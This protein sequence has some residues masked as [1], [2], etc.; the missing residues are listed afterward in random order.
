[1]TLPVSFLRD[2][3]GQLFCEGFLLRYTTGC[4]YGFVLLRDLLASSA[5]LV[6]KIFFFCFFDDFTIGLEVSFYFCRRCKPGSACFLV[7]F[8]FVSL[9]FFFCGR[10]VINWGKKKSFVFFTWFFFLFFRGPKRNVD[11]VLTSAV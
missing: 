8:L 10:V 5:P 7:A 6:L 4:F 2:V 11:V 1:M 3:M 9:F